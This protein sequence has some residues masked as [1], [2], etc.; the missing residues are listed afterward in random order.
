MS[1]LRMLPLKE[2]LKFNKCVYMYKNWTN[3]LPLYLST[4]TPKADT[5]YRSIKMNVV[6]PKPRI[7]LFKS[8]LSYA[9]GTLWNSLPAEIKSSIN[10]SAFKN[11]LLKHL[12]S[13]T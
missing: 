4:V 1:S 7:D 6:I 2:H 9:G 13:C 8:S 12:N 10:L 3:K 11:K 5:T